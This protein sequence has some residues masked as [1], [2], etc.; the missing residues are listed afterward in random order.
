MTCPLRSS[1]DSDVGVGYQGFNAVFPSFWPE[2]IPT[3]SRVSAMAIAQN[4]GTL[5]TALLPTL[6]ATVAPPGSNDIPMTVGSI[7]LASR[8]SPHLQPG[9]R[10]KRIAFR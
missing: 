1:V 4:V 2:L 10:A 3:R 6:F 8:S 9:A 7:S 5:I